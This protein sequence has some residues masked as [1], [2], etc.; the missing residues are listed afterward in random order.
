MGLRRYVRATGAR[1]NHLEVQSSW[2]ST[3]RWV[4]VEAGTQLQEAMFAILGNR[5]LTFPMLATTMCLVEQTLNVRTLTPVSDNP[6][7]ME[8]LT[9]NHFLLGRPVSAETLMY[10][11]VRYVDC[12]KMYKVA[13]AYNQMIWN[14][15]LKE[16]LPKWNVRSKWA[17]DDE[18]VLK[19]GDL[20]WLID[21]SDRRHENKMAR[22]I[23]VLPGAD[24]I[25][26]SASIRTA[27]GV[28][29]R[30]AVMLAPVFF[31]CF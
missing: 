24:D 26:Q 21:E 8:A 1:L 14:R 22:V 4:S 29:R 11:A 19:V 28:F 16:C 12:R 3:L 25:I 10:D 2:S 18:R 15:W 6:E 5:R 31:Q 20:V 7:G 13:Q 27:D 17:T 23:E 9:P 30:P